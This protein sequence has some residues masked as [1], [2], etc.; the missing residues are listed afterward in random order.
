MRRAVYPGSFDP[1]TN[2][3]IDIIK[4]AANQFDEIIV[5]VLRNSSKTPLFSAEER[6]NILNEVLK[7][8]PS[9][10]VRAF[11]GLTVN[12]VKECGAC[13]MIR[14]LRATTDFEYEMQ[15]AH[16]NHELDDTIDT[17]FFITNLEYAYLSSSTVKEIAMYGGD[18]CKFVPEF[19]KNALL[20]K[21][22][23]PERNPAEK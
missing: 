6:V 11:E 15:I 3:H 9:V 13:A 23:R 7:D 17:V 10:S 4:R 19:V 14:G 16:T 18:I 1:V 5:A 12:F 2:G 22:G 20:A 8:M 21:C